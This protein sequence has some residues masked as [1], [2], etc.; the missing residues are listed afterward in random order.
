MK[1]VMCPNADG[2]LLERAIPSSVLYCR[3][4]NTGYDPR[5]MEVVAKVYGS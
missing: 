5:T 3:E 2:G 4:C 1:S